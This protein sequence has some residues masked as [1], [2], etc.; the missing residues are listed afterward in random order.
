MADVE[1]RVKSIDQGSAGIKQFGGVLDGLAGTALKVGAALGA[2]GVAFAG[3]ERAAAAAWQTLGEGAALNDAR[4]DFADLTAEINT[5]ADAMETRLREATGGLVT[6]AQLISDASNLMALNLG[7]TEDEIVDFSGVAA[8]LDW[9]MEALADTLNTGATRGLKEMG[10]NIT[11]VQERMAEL[12][13]QGVATDKAFRMAILE[14]AEEKIG[15]VGKKSEEAAGQIQ[16]IEVAWEEAQNAFSQTFATELSDELGSAAEGAQAL[17][18]NLEYAAEGAA[19][20]AAIVAGGFLNSLAAAGQTGAMGDLAQQFIDLGGNIEDIRREFPTAFSQGRSNAEATGEAIA[21]LQEEVTRLELAAARANP[22]LNDLVSSSYADN[23]RDAAAS[24][25]IYATDMEVWGTNTRAA[26]RA[27]EELWVTVKDGGAAYE[28]L[29]EMARAGLD[30]A[31]AAAEEAATAMAAAYEEAG[32]RMGQ[33]FSQA[34]E[35][36]AMPDFGDTGAMSDMAWD[37]AQAFGLTV[38]QVGNVGIALGELTPDMAEAATK[39]VLFQEAFGLLLGQLQAGNLDTSGF[40]AAYDALIADLQSK[41]LVE[42]QVELKQKENPARDLW[43]WLPA[44]ERQAVDIPVTFTPEE[45]ALQNVL[46]QID[47]IPGEQT[48]VII[49]EADA[50][51]VIGADGGGGAVYEIEQAIAE[52]DTGVAFVP[53]TEAVMTAIR[54]LSAP[55][56]VPVIPVV[57]GS[58]GGSV[59]GPERIGGRG[60]NLDMTVNFNGPAEPRAVQSALTRGLHEFYADVGREGVR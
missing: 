23:V 51:S 38:E 29:G 12:E 7:L 60:L 21:Y 8:E 14:E 27:A 6:N 56:Y 45:A 28:T 33:A 36:G 48:K 35:P 40:V 18:D 42:I 58:P 54:T 1:V 9:N 41:S 55:I 26:R 13:E 15:R 31:R 46:G 52:I 43:A 30:D 19:K 57:Q 5:T 3:I 25:E 10:L 22:E 59:T 2:A 24:F 11:N 32:V 20:L 17:G 53:D 50:A 16:R 44:E 39:A 49:F 47:G 34:L 37:M 4:G